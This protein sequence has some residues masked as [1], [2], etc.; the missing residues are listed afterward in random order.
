MS[1]SQPKIPRAAWDEQPPL[2]QFEEVAEEDVNKVMIQS[3]QNIKAVTKYSF[4]FKFSSCHLQILQQKLQC[5]RMANSLEKPLIGP[6]ILC[7]FPSLRHLWRLLPIF[8]SFFY[9]QKVLVLIFKTPMTT[10]FQIKII[11]RIILII[12]FKLSPT[13]KLL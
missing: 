8:S 9:F 6:N 10:Q 4:T 12:F 7:S 13:L 2:E 5:R 11:S 3:G 1:H